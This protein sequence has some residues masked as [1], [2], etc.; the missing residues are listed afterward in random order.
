[1]IQIH[2]KEIEQIKSVMIDSDN[3]CQNRQNKL[4]IAINNYI[5]LF[6]RNVISQ[7]SQC[8]QYLRR[9]SEK[10]CEFENMGMKQFLRA[11]L[12]N[13]DIPSMNKWHK[14]N[15]LKKINANINTLKNNKKLKKLNKLLKTK[16]Q[17]NPTKFTGASIS[18]NRRIQ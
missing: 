16:H 17:D 2:T 3:C 5:I 10:N 1:M 15:K 4:I 7:W 9:S 13:I 12:L 8:S 6:N 14:W 18:Y 11:H